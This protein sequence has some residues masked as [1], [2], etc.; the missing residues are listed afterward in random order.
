MEACG[1]TVAQEIRGVTPFPSFR[2]SMMDGYAVH[3]P[4]TP[5]IYPVHQRV[6]A[7]DT[8]DDE[9]LQPGKVA[10]ITTGARVP[11]GATGVI[12]IEDTET[13]VVDTDGGGDVYRPSEKSVNI[14]KPV[15]E[16]SNIR[17]IGSDID[18]GDV[19]LES[20]QLVEPAEIGLLA[21][22][23]VVNVPCYRKPVIGIMSTGN[24]LVEVWETPTGSQIRDS[25]RAALLTAFQR[26]GYPCIDLGIVMDAVAEL[27][28]RLLDA[29]ARCDVVVTSGGVSMGAADL[30]KPLLAKLGTVQFGRLNMK[31]GKPTTF[32][33][34]NTISGGSEAEGATKMKKTL[35]FGLPGNPVSCLVTK[36]LMIDPCL[37]RLQGH[38]IADSMHAQVVATIGQDLKLDPERPEYHRA[39]LSLDPCGGDVAR[40]TSTGMYTK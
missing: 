39:L 5:G 3:A 35:F 27:E 9:P 13:V 19:L 16:G 28:S 7:G 37:R 22:A 17:Q 14:L 10:Y 32:A 6:H 40:A 24:E 12:K 36:A 34:I 1:R 25:N 21:T 26:D 11:D 15:S 8:A 30:V 4:L 20:G 18:V 2:A 23:G 29:A 38:S 33:T 31:P